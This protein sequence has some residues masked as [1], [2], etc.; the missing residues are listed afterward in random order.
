MGL[1]KNIWNLDLPWS[2]GLLSARAWQ[3]GERTVVSVPE[4]DILCTGKTQSEAVFRLF[5]IL[6]KYYNE[7][8]SKSL[9]LSDK[10]AHR[11]QLLSTWVQSVE[12]KMMGTKEPVSV[13]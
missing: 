12:K 9:P 2:N 11:L 3:K 1:A 10:D 5:S 8:K 13:S 6:L 4:L 7:L